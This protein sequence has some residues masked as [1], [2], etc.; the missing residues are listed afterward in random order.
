[1]NTTHAA[2]QQAPS[3]VCVTEPDAP[4]PVYAT[5]PAGLRSAIDSL[6]SLANQARSAGAGSY[7]TTA[8]MVK[9]RRLAA[10]MVERTAELQAIVGAPPVAVQ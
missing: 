3:P 7:V 1:M 6:V 10:E 5:A 8:S 2:E 4:E 9:L